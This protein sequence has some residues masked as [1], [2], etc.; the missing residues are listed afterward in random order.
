MGLGSWL[1][2]GVERGRVSRIQKTES[3]PAFTA[4]QCPFQQEET[5]EQVDSFPPPTKS[6]KKWSSTTVC[7]LVHEGR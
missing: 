7:V 4:G 1:V 6:S 2:E 3:F 5:V